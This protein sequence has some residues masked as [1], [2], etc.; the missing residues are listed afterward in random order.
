MPSYLLQVSYTPEALSALIADPQNRAD[1]VRKPIEH[2]GGR[3]INSW[4][5]FDEYDL[6]TVIEMPDNVSAAAFALAI[7]AGGSLKAVK[8]TPLLTLEE[9]LKA[10]ELAATSGY[11]PVAI[12]K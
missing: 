5:S 8:T 7:S 11:E 10:M 6:V 9:G 1:A 12:D 2:L 4:L 3:V